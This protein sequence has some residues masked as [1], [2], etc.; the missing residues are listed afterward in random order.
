M[1]NHGGNGNENVGQ[2]GEDEVRAPMPVIRDVL[3]DDAALYGYVL[4][5]HF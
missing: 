4:S 2:L 5:L 1:V 3:Y